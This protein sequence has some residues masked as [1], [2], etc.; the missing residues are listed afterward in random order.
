MNRS[1]LDRVADKVLRESLRIQAEDTV[2]IETWNTGLEF[3]ERVAVRAREIGTTPVLL[4]EDEDAFVEGLRKTPREFI[5]NMGRH[6]IALLSRTNAY[7][8]IPSPAIGGLGGSSTLSREEYAA[9]TAYNSSWYAAAKKARIRGARMLFGYVGPERA[10]ILCKPIERIVEHHLRA[11]LV[12]LSKVRRQG[13]AL[14][15]RLK[16]ASR[17]TLIA[18]GERLEFELG[19]AEALDDGIVDRGDLATGGNMVNMP[20][21]YYAREIIPSSLTG[22][23]RMYAPVP[24]IGAVADLRLHFR[25]GRL[26]KWESEGA[27]QWL[28]RLVAATPKDRRTPVAIVVG[29]NSELRNGYGQDRLVEGAV[30]LMGLFQGTTRGASLEV[31]ETPVIGDD[32]LIPGRD[33]RRNSRP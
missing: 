28:N 33:A 32:R 12:D 7:V 17:V 27:R 14:S 1:L 20:P 11:S 21:G 10:R 16:P 9:S 19:K 2:T 15:A 5:G 23:V 25:H 30:T 13:L 6:E 26:I 22:V 29:L 8:F 31:N 3:A 24:R 4:F 18:E